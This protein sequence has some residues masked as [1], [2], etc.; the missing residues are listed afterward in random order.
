MLFSESKQS[1]QNVQ[2][3]KGSLFHGPTD[4]GGR[5]VR[6]A[7]K[8][9]TELISQS[10]PTAGNNWLSHWKQVYVERSGADVN[11]NVIRCESELIS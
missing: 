8:I 7:E 2:Q 6:G 4:A 3:I 11:M 1:H 9:N 10:V 5:F